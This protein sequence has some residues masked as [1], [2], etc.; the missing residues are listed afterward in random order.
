[1]LIII[2]LFKLIYFNILSLLGGFNFCND[3]F[4]GEME[5][6]LFEKNH[7]NEISSVSSDFLKYG[8][9]DI[10][11]KAFDSPY[12]PKKRFMLMKANFFW[13]FQSKENFMLKKIFICRCA[14]ATET[15][16]KFDLFGNPPPLLSPPPHGHNLRIYVGLQ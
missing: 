9:Y 6:D 7:F 10:S 16:D 1:M 13:V 14:V 12:Q 11:E 8:K 3:D 15:M 5:C 4:I 2:F